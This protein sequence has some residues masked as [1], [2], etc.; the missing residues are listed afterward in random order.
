MIKTTFAT[1]QE[2]L[3]QLDFTVTRVAESHYLFEHADPKAWLALRLYQPEETVAPAALAYVR[4]TLDA[5]GIL[6]RDQF[7]EQLRQRTLAS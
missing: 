5:F 2:F 3:V 6:D 1:L 7:D 4:H